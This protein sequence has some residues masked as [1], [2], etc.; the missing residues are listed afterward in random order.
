MMHRR[1]GTGRRPSAAVRRN[2]RWRLVAAAALAALWAAS[3]GVEAAPKPDPTAG[4]GTRAAVRP[5]A[6]ATRER[7]GLA[8]F[9]A[10]GVTGDGVPVFASSRAEDGALLEAARLVR[11]MLTGAPRLERA[12]V[13]ANLRVTVMAV[14]EFT[15]NVP[16]HSGLRPKTYWDRRARG[17]GGTPRRPVVS[18]GEENLL[19]LPGDPYRGENILIHEFAHA[20]HLVGMAAIDP[21]F[22]RRLRAA[23][24][25]AKRDGLWGG[26]YAITRPAEYFAEGVQDW[27]GCNM[28]TG[29]LYSKL[30]TRDALGR[31]DP[32]LTGLLAEAFGEN[33]WRYEGKPAAPSSAAAKRFAWPD[34]LKSPVARA[35]DAAP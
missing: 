5:I 14:D 26:T 8:P 13:S 30:T 23:Y 12:L 4:R 21:G 29:P 35:Y 1:G 31:Y 10:K 16:E 18:C 33:A 15:T 6:P 17:L 28:A 34:R 9:Y 22:D 24:D 27:F 7:Y 2:G 32:R 11:R 25:A 20:V 3:R 19:G